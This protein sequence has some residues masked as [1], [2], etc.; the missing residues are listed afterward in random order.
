MHAYQSKEDKKK[1]YN[2]YTRDIFLFLLICQSIGN[3]N[4][5]KKKYFNFSPKLCSFTRSFIHKT[6]MHS[7][8]CVLQLLFIQNPN[9]IHQQC[10]SLMQCVRKKSISQQNIPIMHT[11]ISSLCYS[12]IHSQ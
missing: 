6:F 5:L 1:K 2:K 8:S 3:K 10:S 11:Q 12:C 4:N 9:I 7:L